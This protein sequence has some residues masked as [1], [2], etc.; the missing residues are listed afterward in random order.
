MRPSP[1][2]ATAS[3][4]LSPRING[5]GSW[6]PA[7]T[8]AP[9]TRM[10]TK[11]I[12][13]PILTPDKTTRKEPLGTTTSLLLRESIQLARGTKVER[14]VRDRRC[15]GN[16]LAELWVCGNQFRLGSPG[17]E[18]RD[19]PIVERSKVNMSIRC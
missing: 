6:S 1:P 4:F 3:A 19:D 12:I 11:T 7:E 8:G 16:A 2:T 10:L 13:W 15:C 14:I 18:D 17:L 9:L 5:C